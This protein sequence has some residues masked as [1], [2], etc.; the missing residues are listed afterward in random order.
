M[1]N[2][3]FNNSQQPKERKNSL[4]AAMNREHLSNMDDY[5]EYYYG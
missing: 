4:V 3:Y 1:G 5:P 2:P